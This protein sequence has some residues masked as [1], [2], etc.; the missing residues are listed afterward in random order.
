LDVVKLEPKDLSELTLLKLSRE[1]ARDIH[2]I[3]S[4]LERFGID[5]ELW[6][7]IRTMPRFI[8][9]LQHEIETW[10]SAPN[11]SERVK[12]KSLSFVEELLP[13]MYERA[14]DPRE[15]L[16]SKV[17][18]L[19]TVGRFGGVGVSTSEGGIGEK[20]SVTINLGADKELKFE[21]DVTPPVVD[22]LG[23]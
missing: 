10:N 7:D 12:I 18:L 14:H 3:E 19:K 21:K 2:P 1:I 8:S 20:L 23:E 9:F 15:T 22:V 17:E 5:A 11:T 16:S 6:S 4:I 13:E